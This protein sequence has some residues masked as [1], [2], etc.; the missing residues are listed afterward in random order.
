MYCLKKFSNYLINIICVLILYGIIFSLI[1]TGLLNNYYKGIIVLIMISI[2]L[3]VS[4]N[5]VTGFLGQLTLGHAGF[6]A[7][8]A[9]TSA[10]FTKYVELPSGIEFLL[11]LIL[12]GLLAGV[13]GIIIGIPALR[14]KGDYI[15][16]L[17]LGFGEMIRGLIIYFSDV[18]GG[19]KGFIGIEYYSNFTI[20]FIITVLTIYILNTLINSRHG[21]AIL[22][23]REDEIA[24]EASGINTVYYK[25]FAFSISAFFAGIAGS[26][27]AHYQMVLDPVKFN[28][29]YS[30]EILIMVVLGGMGSMTGSIV[31]TIILVAIPQVL[32]EFS[33]YRMLIYSLLLILIMIFKPSGLFGR[34]EFSM[35]K[36]IHKFMKKNK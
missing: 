21:R 28:Y 27:F 15:A 34:Y 1:S 25:I 36:L 29:N 5:L 3:S 24:A 14:L 20:V 17:T 12:S 2:I 9:Y 23:I 18:T 32:I 22:S 13:F 31:A 4:L 33:Q 16:I 7:I 11:A 30:I 10:I 19:A 35:S 6:M 26:L 8:G